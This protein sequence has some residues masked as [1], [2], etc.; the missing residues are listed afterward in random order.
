MDKKIGFIGAGNISSTIICGLIDGFNDIHSKIYVT[1]PST[2][3]GE[4]LAIKYKI[5]FVK[6]NI[7]L[8]KTCDIIFLG[9]KPNVYKIVLNEIAPYINKDKLIISIAAAIT[10]GDVQGYFNQPQRVLRIMPNIGVTVGEGMIPMSCSPQVSD[11]D[12]AL[13]ISLLQTIGR[14]DLIDEAM[15][16]AVTIIS[17]CS[18]AFIALFVEALADGGVLQGMPREKTYQYVAQTLVGTGKLILEKEIHPGSLKDLVTSPGGVAI[19]G[20]YSLESQGF[21]SIVIKSLEA[22]KEKL[23]ILTKK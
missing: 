18:P 20:V 9:V 13:I 17:G 6:G 10:I 11:S 12:L 1:N 22:C 23:K 21:R 7:E 3:K 8:A 14:V 16:N 19:E 5:N 4:N 2:E 15:M